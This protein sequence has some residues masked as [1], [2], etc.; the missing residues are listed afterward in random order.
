MKNLRVTVNGKIYEVVVEEVEKDK[1]SK[2]KFL[3]EQDEKN[4]LTLDN[5]EN[6]SIEKNVKIEGTAIKAPMPGTIVSVKVETGKKVLKGETLIILEA[7]KMENEIV[8]PFDGEI[9]YIDVIKGD[10]VDSGKDLI[11]LK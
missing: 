9:T 10:Y 4:E 3:K 2:E 11:F 7:M 1:S 8:A 6:E 5:I